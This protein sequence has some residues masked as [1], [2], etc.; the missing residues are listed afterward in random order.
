MKFKV[1][2]EEILE[3]TIDIDAG[4]PFEAVSKAQ[5]MYADEEIVLTADDFVSTE[6]Y[7]DKYEEKGE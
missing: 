3:R 7:A 4:N 6:F 1:T 2:I 5:Q